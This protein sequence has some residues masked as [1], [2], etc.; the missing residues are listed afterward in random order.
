MTIGHCNIDHQADLY[1]TEQVIA[2]MTCSVFVIHKPGN[3]NNDHRSLQIWHALCCDVPLKQCSGH[4]G[5]F[6]QHNA[7]HCNNDQR[8]L[9]QWPTLCYDVLL[10]NV[11]IILTMTTGHCNND[12]RSDLYCIE[13]VIA[14]MTKSMFIVHSVETWSVYKNKLTYNY[15]EID[16]I[17]W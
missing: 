1:Y 13:Q 10:K 12:H 7:C 8:S 2:T 14:S 9:Q 15:K 11:I 3:C 16:K 4:S 17:V 5:W 6:V